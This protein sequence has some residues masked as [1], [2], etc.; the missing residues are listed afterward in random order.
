MNLKEEVQIVN[1]TPAIAAEWLAHNSHNR[2]LRER[3]ATMYATDMINGDWRWTGETVKFNYDGSLSDGQHRLRGVVIA[4]ETKPNISV[5]F[6]VV[7][8]LD[9]ASQEDIDRGLPRKFSDVLALRGEANPSALGALVR[10]VHNWEDNRRRNLFQISSYTVAQLLRTLDAHPELRETVTEA[11]RLAGHC[12]L[13]GSMIGLGLWIFAQIDEEDARYFFERLADG[14]GLVK[15]DPIYELR[16]HL[17]NLK[18]NV[19]GERS[20]TYMFAVLIK[21]WNA[22]RAGEKVGVYKW[23]MGGAKPEAFPEPK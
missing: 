1:V 22:Y 15:G 9:P 12:D 17:N 21:A 5:P 19:R 23:R 4:G 2:N 3:V 14:Q 18:Q 16:N 10:I 20:R 11:Q 7:T 6:L 13:S 8:G